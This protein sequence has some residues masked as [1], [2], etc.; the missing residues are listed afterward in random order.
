MTL[1][2]KKISYLNVLYNSLNSLNFP[3]FKLVF[4]ASN[5]VYLVYLKHVEWDTA[6]GHLLSNL[7]QMFLNVLYDGVTVLV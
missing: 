6:I 4:I 1:K 2:K 3:H 5:S 7:N